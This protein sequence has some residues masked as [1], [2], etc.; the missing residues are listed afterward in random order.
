[1]PLY[2]KNDSPISNI[3]KKH[4]E[5]DISAAFERPN[6]RARY[7]MFDITIMGKYDEDADFRAFALLPCGDEKTKRKKANE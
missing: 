6:R 4:V 5:T 2:A 7:K 1:M 3:A